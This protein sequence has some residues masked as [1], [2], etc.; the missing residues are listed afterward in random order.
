VVYTCQMRLV[1][2]GTTP[3]GEAEAWA[4]TEAE[5]T[6]RAL[7]QAC[8]RAGG[9][10]ACGAEEDGWVTTTSCA[11]KHEGDVRGFRCVARAA[12]GG[13]AEATAES[14]LTME[15]A[16]GAALVAACRVGRGGDD[17]TGLQGGW[18]LVERVRGLRAPTE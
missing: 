18:Q 12:R 4:E 9:A 8:Q 6:A 15:A 2:R 17:C 11:A 16:C 3:Y 10:A 5:A 7:P 13:I 1:D 14:N